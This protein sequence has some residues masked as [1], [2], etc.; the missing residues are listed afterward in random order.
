MRSAVLLVGGFV[1]LAG[2]IAVLALEV[3][4]RWIA[5]PLLIVVGIALKLVGVLRD[6]RPAPV[7]PG[8]TKTTLGT[9]PASTTAAAAPVRALGAQAA[10]RARQTGQVS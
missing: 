8:R 4:G 10:R 5:G 3:P 1:L 2:G 6:P 9:A 7:A